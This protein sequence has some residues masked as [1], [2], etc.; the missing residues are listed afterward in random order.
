[1][2]ELDKHCQEQQRNARCL[3]KQKSAASAALHFLSLYH[4]QHA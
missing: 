1:M 4:E 3:P 2:S